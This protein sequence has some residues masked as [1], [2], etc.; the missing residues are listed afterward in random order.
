MVDFVILSPKNRVCT[1]TPGTPVT[2]GL[3]FEFDAQPIVLIFSSLKITSL[4]SE[5]FSKD[6]LFEPLTR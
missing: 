4:N 6:T 2:M 3:L 1:C 5:T